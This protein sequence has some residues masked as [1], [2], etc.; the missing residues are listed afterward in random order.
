MS[1]PKKYLQIH[2]AD[3]VLVALQDLVE[4]EEINFDGIRFSLPNRVKAKHKFSFSSFE[5]EHKIVMYGVLVGKT[6]HPLKQGELLTTENIYHAAE[7]FE[8]RER[9]LDWHKPNVEHFKGRTFKGF[10]RSNGDVGTAN[11]WIVI[12]MVFCENQN[13]LTMKEALKSQKAMSQKSRK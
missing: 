11:H 13:V 2:P 12:P 6:S 10:H 9:K 1:E 7:D 4:G 3:N 5:K 8:L